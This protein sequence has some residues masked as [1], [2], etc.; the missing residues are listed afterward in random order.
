M[1]DPAKAKY[2]YQ[3][4]I[5]ATSEYVYVYSSDGGLIRKLNIE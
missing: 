5:P 1:S 2:K 4:I 3:I